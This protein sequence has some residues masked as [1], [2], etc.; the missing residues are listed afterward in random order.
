MTEVDPIIE[1]ADEN[2]RPVDAEIG[3]DGALY[4]ADW[5]NPIIGHMQHNLRDTS[6]DHEHGRIYRVTYEGRPLQPAA[7]AGEPIDRLLDLLKEP[8]DRVRYRA[9]IELSGRNSNDV[10]SALNT[11][12]SRRRR[13]RSTST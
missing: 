2:F 9:K 12:I 4:I 11:W 3:A 10:L 6:R 1:S 13:A 7:I 8:E 5:Q